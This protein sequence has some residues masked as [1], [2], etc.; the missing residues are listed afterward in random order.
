[1][2]RDVDVA[3]IG[4]G[5]AGINA[6]SEV[7][8]ITD[9]FVLING[10]ILGTTC[11]RVGCMPSKILIQ[12]A[13]DYH[14]RWVFDEEGIERADRL[15]LDLGRS[16]GYLRKLRN[17]FTGGVIDDVI[18]PLGDKLIAGYCEFLEPNL[19]RV[20]NTEI[21]AGRIVIAAGSRP[22]V[23]ERWRRFGD[24]I[25]TTDT[26]FEQSELPRDLAV[27]GL[28]AIG[29]EVG[30][31]LARLGLNIAGFDALH[32]IGGLQDPEI[33]R[34]A[35]EIFRHELPIHLSAAVDIQEEN[36]RLRVV[37]AETTILTDKVLLSMGRVS[38]VDRLRL[39][40]LGIELDERGLPPFDPQTMQIP[41]LPIFIAG[42]INDY[43]PVLH[44]A[45]HEG[46]V[47]GYNA[48]HDPPVAFR[49]KTPLVI[50][51]TDPNICIAGAPWGDVEDDGPA[52][53]R[54]R[55]TGGRERIMLREEGMIRIYGQRETGR[56]LGAEMAAPS[57]EHLAHQV[58]WSIQQ[59]QT[60]FDLLAMPF[61]HPAVEETLQKALKDLAE[62]VQ[63]SGGPLLGFEAAGSRQHLG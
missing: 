53:G 49:R 36:G 16:M 47:A 13:D 43:R 25:L 20:E 38:N 58:A 63:P 29:L 51:F 27:I 3:I 40:R 1:M 12:I 34:E 59:G 41:G 5:T 30:Q 26:I 57:G 28:G 60:V 15:F 31:A 9:D 37:S 10:G 62:N 39:D 2:K 19:L 61:Y 7:G 23:P 45:Y 14:R 4:A 52:V 42:D 11:A 22:I 55:F 46:K 56:I 50:A 24:R 48:V 32:R 17:G 8:K 6:M 35:V 54:A 33:S 44:E 18:A 21:R